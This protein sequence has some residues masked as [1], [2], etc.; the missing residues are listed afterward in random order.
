M[1]RLLVLRK[2]QRTKREQAMDELARRYA[3]AMVIAKTSPHAARMAAVGAKTYATHRWSTAPKRSKARLLVIPVAVVGGV[4]VARKVR[5]N[6]S[7]NGHNPD[8]DRPLGPVATADTVSPPADAAAEAAKA[9]EAQT[10]DTA[11]TS[12]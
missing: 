7:S 11:E 10:A 6:G 3:H 12:S 8:F 2:K 5:N 1:A 9:E 4:V